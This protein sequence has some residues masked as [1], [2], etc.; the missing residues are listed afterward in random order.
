MKKYSSDET[1]FV[2]AQKYMLARRREQLEEVTTMK[3][4]LAYLARQREQLEEGK[5]PN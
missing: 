4:R 5:P 2:F 1:K 3:R